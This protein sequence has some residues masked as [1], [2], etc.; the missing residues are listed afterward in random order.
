MPSLKTYDLFLSHAWRYNADYNNLEKLLKGADYFKWR[1]Y[2]VPQ[3]DPLINPNTPVGKKVLTALLENQVKPV[4]CFLL[5]GGMY[6]LH[7]DWIKKEIELAKK[8]KKPIVAIYPFGSE[9]MPT[10]VQDAASVIVG[11]R[12]SSIIDA[13][14]KYAI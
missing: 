8:Y 11:W 6:A 7:S 4:N 3:H 13:I 14:R 1:N 12:T 2:S 10:T 9:R 5:L